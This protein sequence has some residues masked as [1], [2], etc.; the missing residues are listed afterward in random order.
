MKNKSEVLEMG[1]VYADNICFKELH[2]SL[3]PSGWEIFQ[4]QPFYKDLVDF[5]NSYNSCKRREVVFIDNIEKLIIEEYEQIKQ[6]GKIIF[7]IEEVFRQVHF[8]YPELAIHIKKRMME[9]AR[10]NGDLP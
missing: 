8:K 10:E 4:K 5:I 6:N 9:I 7:G 1:S 3:L 2:I